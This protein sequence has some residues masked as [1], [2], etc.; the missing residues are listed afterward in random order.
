MKFFE[1]LSEKYALFFNNFYLFSAE[2]RGKIRHFDDEGIQV[3][4]GKL[5]ELQ[6]QKIA[7]YQ[8]E[9]LSAVPLAAVTQRSNAPIPVQNVAFPQNVVDPSMKSAV[10]QVMAQQV[11]ALPSAP[12][13]QMQPNRYASALPEQLSAQPSRASLFTNAEPV[14]SEQQPGENSLSRCNLL[15]NHSF[16]PIIGHSSLKS[17]CWAFP[18]WWIL[19]NI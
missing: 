3:S 11:S 19:G 6:R 12:V 14:G 17:T 9:T 2:R 7:Q 5:N 16:Y 8:A 1:L 4:E 13:Q 18:L 15:W 10:P